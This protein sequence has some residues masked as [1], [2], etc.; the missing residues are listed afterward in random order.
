M[1]PPVL[2]KKIGRENTTGGVL[3]LQ[4][5]AQRG[6]LPRNTIPQ[7]PFAQPTPLELRD[8]STFVRVCQNFHSHHIRQARFGFKK[9]QGNTLTL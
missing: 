9:K 5:P 7:Q 6:G 1:V 2:K 3:R 4:K 8:R